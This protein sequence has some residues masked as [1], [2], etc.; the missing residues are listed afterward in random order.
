MEIEA[1]LAGKPLAHLG[2]LVGGVIVQDHMHHLARRNFGLDG[3]KEAD[4]LLMPVALHVAPDDCERQPRLSAV[5]RAWAVQSWIFE[6]LLPRYQ[7]TSLPEATKI[8]SARILASPL[9]SHN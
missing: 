5:D 4:E 1:F 7:R 2:V 6:T 9:N 3:V 8:R